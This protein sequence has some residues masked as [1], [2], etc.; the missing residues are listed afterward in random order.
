[1]AR[2]QERKDARCSAED[3]SPAASPFRG[4]PSIFFFSLLAPRP[5]ATKGTGQFK[6]RGQQRTSEGQ[7]AL[8][9]FLL[10]GRRPVEYTTSC[11]CKKPKRRN[12]KRGGAVMSARVCRRHFLGRGRGRGTGCVDGGSDGGRGVRCT[13][14]PEARL[15]PSA[16]A[17]CAGPAAGSRE[18]RPCSRMDAG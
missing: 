12:K 17:P 6:A 3:A 7:L 2:G 8:G 11:I 9:A 4:E 18:D 13:K 5:S 1:M 16:S 15:S 10:P 14:G